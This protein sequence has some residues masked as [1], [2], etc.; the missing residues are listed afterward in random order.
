MAC[1]VLFP[2]SYTPSVQTSIQLVMPGYDKY[3]LSP[4]DD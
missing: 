1:G 2:Q 3:Q 4:G